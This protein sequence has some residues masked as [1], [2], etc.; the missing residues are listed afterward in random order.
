MKKHVLKYFIEFSVIVLS[1]TISFYVEKQ[2]AISYKQTLKNQSLRRISKNI[3]IDIND[4]NY[5]IEAHALASEAIE[6]LVNN[7]SNLLSQSKDTI[8]EKISNA[9]LVNTVFVD[10]QEEYRALQNSGLIELIE[11]EIVV[12]ALQNK[13]NSHEFYKQLEI[14]IGDSSKPLEEFVFSNTKLVNEKT[15]NLGFRSERRFISNEKIPHV[16]IERLKNKKWFHDFYIER[17]KRR[18]EKDLNLIDLINQEI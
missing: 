15:N 10:N 12:E 6:W 7:N 17:I 5:N 8:G 18:I 16:I 3:E 13:Y 14:A 9:I 1:I 4:M 11:V 2:N